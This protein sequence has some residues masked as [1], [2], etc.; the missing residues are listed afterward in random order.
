MLFYVSC[1]I[2]IVASLMDRSLVQEFWECFT[3]NVFVPL[4]VSAVLLSI[5]GPPVEGA[6]VAHDDWMEIPQDR[7]ELSGLM[8]AARG[9]HIL[10]PAE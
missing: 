4:F 3:F 6:P 5:A 10:Q 2:Y 1:V 8:A 9:P 7:E